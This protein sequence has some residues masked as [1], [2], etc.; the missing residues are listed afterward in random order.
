MKKII[1]VD[2]HGNPIPQ[3]LESVTL[4]LGS[5]GG[6]V[7]IRRTPGIPINRAVTGNDGRRYVIRSE[8]VGLD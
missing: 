1:P 4:Y 3:K 8:F 7:T 5:R 6:S 2:F